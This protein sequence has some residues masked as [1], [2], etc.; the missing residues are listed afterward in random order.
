MLELLREQDVAERFRKLTAAATKSFVAVPFWGKGSPGLLGLNGGQRAK[1]ICN[2]DSGACNPYVIE[3]LDNCRS[4]T[5][6]SHPRLHAKIY[7]SREFVIIGSSNAS[8]NGLVEGNPTSWI[9]ANVISTEP[10]LVNNTIIFFEKIWTEATEV[11]SESISSAKRRWDN[12]P[13]T[14]RHLEA[15]LLLAAC[16]ERPELFDLVYVAAYT[17]ELGKIGKQK[18]AAYRDA[19]RRGESTIDLDGI[20]KAWG[21]QFEGIPEH[22]WLVVINC[23]N[24]SNARF[25]GYARATSPLLA[26]AAGKERDV[27]ITI[28][29]PTIKIQTSEGTCDFKL[30]DSEIKALNSNAGR[31]IRNDYRLTPLKEA[32]D[33][34]NA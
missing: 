28:E 4:I 20:R 17:E 15:E 32:V 13:T 34:V 8:T 30:S 33:I 22:A 18:E 31:L 25:V 9:E 16:K 26:L 14:P 27:I 21:Y 2:L 11:T 23:K 7:A 3:E 29:K 10:S 12:R 5:L 1:I 24:P 19:I 6:R